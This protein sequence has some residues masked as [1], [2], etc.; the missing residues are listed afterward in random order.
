MTDGQGAG[1]NPQVRCVVTFAGA[2]AMSRYVM[3]AA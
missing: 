3:K 1:T 2:W